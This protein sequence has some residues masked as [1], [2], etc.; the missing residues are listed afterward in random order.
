[1]YRVTNT[2]DVSSIN[3]YFAQGNAVEIKLYKV[4]TGGSFT[5]LGG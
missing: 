4:L 3:G 5:Q 2:G 1:M